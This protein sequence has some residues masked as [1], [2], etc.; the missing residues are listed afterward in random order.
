[1]TCKRVWD[2]TKSFHFSSYGKESNK[3]VGGIR[4]PGS[5]RASPHTRLCSRTM[6]IAEWRDLLGSDAFWNFQG[7]MQ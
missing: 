1:M 6:R 7:S 3:S 2:S 4:C 5:D